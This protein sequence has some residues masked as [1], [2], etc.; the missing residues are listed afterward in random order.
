M[1]N[2]PALSS[3][4]KF[5]PHLAE[6]SD[7]KRRVLGEASGT[8]AV[9]VCSVTRATLALPTNELLSLLRG[10]LGL[11]SWLLDPHTQS[12]VPSTG[13]VQLVLTFSWRRVRF[14]IYIYF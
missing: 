8:D 7:L 9:R 12:R 14:P 1:E 13:A 5:E 11:L 2:S 10:D 4:E 6:S 3:A